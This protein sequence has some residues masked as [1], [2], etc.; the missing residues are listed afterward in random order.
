MGRSGESFGTVPVYYGAQYRAVGKGRVLAG[1]WVKGYCVG[2]WGLKV[3][4]FRSSRIT[5]DQWEKHEE[6]AVHYVNLKASID[7]YYNENIVYRDQTYQLV[8]ASMS[9]LKKSITS[10][11]DLYKGLEVIT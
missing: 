11:I 9:S 5:E 4:Q 10:I 3:W 8:E 1:K 2:S 6:A 7:D